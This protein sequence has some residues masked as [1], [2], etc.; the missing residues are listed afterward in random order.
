MIVDSAD[1]EI[2]PPRDGEAERGANDVPGEVAP[3]GIAVAGEIVELLCGSGRERDARADEKANVAGAR[4][5]RADAVA[6]AG[7]DGREAEV[8]RLVAAEPGIRIGGAGRWGDDED[9]DGQERRDEARA[10]RCARTAQRCAW[11]AATAFAPFCV[12]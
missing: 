2:E 8:E 9:D 3:R 11:L 12:A 10:R 1:R 5:G 7:E 4:E 6:S